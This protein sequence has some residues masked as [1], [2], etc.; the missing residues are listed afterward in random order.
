VYD[1]FDF[2]SVVVLAQFVFGLSKARGEVTTGPSQLS[3][4]IAP[5]E[6][7]DRLEGLGIE[8]S[9]AWCADFLHSRILDKKRPQIVG[10]WVQENSSLCFE[11]VRDRP[12]RHVSHLHT[13][14]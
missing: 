11:M 8:V 6:V 7:K 1:A 4:A 14:V 9:A 12:A 13:L 2:K 10:I 3:W 5:P